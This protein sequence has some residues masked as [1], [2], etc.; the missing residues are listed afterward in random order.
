MTA[1]VSPRSPE[2]SAVG[3]RAPGA[4]TRA[5]TFGSGPEHVGLDLGDGTHG[6]VVHSHA[7]DPWRECQEF[8]CGR[9]GVDTRDA[10]VRP[11]PI[12]TDAS[13]ARADAGAAAIRE[14]KKARAA[15]LWAEAGDPRG[16]LVETYLRSRASTTHARSPGTCCASTMACPF[17]DEEDRARRLPAMIA[18]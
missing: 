5:G 1:R 2:R 9:L 17:R 18:A 12:E 3:Y 6:I 11:A 14:R 4:R 16:S 13:A 10:A 15:A 7:G 8:V